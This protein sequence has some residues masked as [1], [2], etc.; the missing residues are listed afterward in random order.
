RIDG[1]ADDSV[2]KH[3]LDRTQVEL[4]FTGA[5]FGNVGQPQPIWRISG[6]IPA[7]QIVMYGWAGFAVL[8]AFALTEHTPPAVGR[9]DSPGGTLG[10]RL[11]GIAGLGDQEPVAE[12]RIIAMGVE[13]SVGAVSLGPLGI[14]HGSGQPTVVGLAGELED[15]ARHRH[16]DT[17]RGELFHYGANPFS[18]QLD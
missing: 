5:V 18:R 12:F 6:E 14:G 8:T 2:G 15:P 16:R 1:V 7:D 4:A 3:V 13:Q 9:T 17:G 10:H 11:P